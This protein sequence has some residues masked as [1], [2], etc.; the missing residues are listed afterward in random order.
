[1]Q[2]LQQLF[3]RLLRGVWEAGTARLVLERFCGFILYIPTL[4]ELKAS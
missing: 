2:Q 1:M 3:G 4:C